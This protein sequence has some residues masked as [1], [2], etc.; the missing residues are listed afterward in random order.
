MSIDKTGLVVFAVS[1]YLGAPTWCLVMVLV[2]A[3]LSAQYP[4]EHG[5]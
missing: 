2:V 5:A 3:L 4:P 1:W